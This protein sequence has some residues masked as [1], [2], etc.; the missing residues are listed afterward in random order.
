MVFNLPVPIWTNYNQPGLQSAVENLADSTIVLTWGEA[1]PTSFA[2]KVY[3]LIYYSTT[4][5]NLYDYPKLIAFD[6]TTVAIPTTLVSTTMY[7]G[8][9]V[10]QFG[11]S[12]IIDSVNFTEISDN[13]YSLAQPT[14]L[15][16]D[17]LVSD[18][19][20]Q[21]NSTSGFPLVD[22]YIQ[23]D[24]EVIFYSSLD[25]YNF[26]DA[27]QV[28]NRDP[29]STNAIISHLADGYRTV[30]LFLGAEDQNKIRF[31]SIEACG[32]PRPYWVDN[33]EI[34]LRELDDLGIGTSVRLK[35]KYAK[36]PEGFGDVYYNVY[37]SRS[38]Y[39]IVLNEPFAIT[40]A[41]EIIDPNLHPGDGYY[42]IVRAAYF[43]NPPILNELSEISEGLYAYPSTTY[44]DEVDG[45]FE[46]ANLG[47]LTVTT[48]EGF[49]TQGLLKIGSE[50]LS[51]D[52]ITAT[53]FNITERD[54]FT[55]DYVEDYTNGTSV[56]L[57]RGI[58]D[59]NK[60]FY[61][62]VASW[63]TGSIAIQMPLVPG[64]GY[65][66][67]AYLQDR[68]GYRSFPFDNINEDHS[69]F[70][71]NNDDVLP[72]SYCGYR[73]ETFV[74]LY[75]QQQC[76]T[77]QGGSNV[78]RVIPGVNG[79][80][81]VR[82]GGGIDVYE[83]NLQRQE[84]LLG[85]TGEPFILLRR[86]TTGQVCQR[87][88]HRHEHPHARCSICFGTGFSGGYD[89]FINSREIRPTELNPNGF[90]QLRVQPYADKAPLKQDLGI[91]VS[92]VLY[93]AWTL[94][95][96]TIKV[97]DVLINYISDIEFGVLIEDFRY[98]V[99][100]VQRNKLLFSKEG[101]QKLTL[102]RIPKTEQVY[103]YPEGGIILI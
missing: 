68:D 95:I 103:T 36:A 4:T 97:R 99:I 73:R 18:G 46:S 48:T 96:P 10:A 44:I 42:Y 71:E 22:G 67:Y 52:S 100:N 30:S 59:L 8:V 94:A 79:G 82:I 77:Y 47:A 15:R 49:P 11:I 62:V 72:Q 76:G 2:T 34:G 7:F 35:W 57:F 21:A 101:A 31:K 58:E 89:R 61:K 19:Y 40:Q 87:I 20:V 6:T 25:G 83:S 45:Y 43:I 27:F 88:S 98:E 84:F 24:D 63:D 56:V 64:D 60:V 3:Y 50:I 81:P 23:V 75:Q 85:L 74:N 70:E 28:E 14:L 13:L 32:F 90:I 41:N 17:F 55:L 26:G 102:K 37:K 16:E 29:Y 66:G 80:R 65:D 9:R 93:E 39:N 1:L 69:I 86:K 78:I 12:N 91:D 54:V 38:L 5:T 33:L 92:E 53:T 51:Y